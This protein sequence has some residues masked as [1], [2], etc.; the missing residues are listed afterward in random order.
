MDRRPDEGARRSGLTDTA[1]GI[2]WLVVLAIGVMAAA[3]AM[4]AVMVALMP[5]T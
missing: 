5:E 2:G 4:I 1:R 3:L